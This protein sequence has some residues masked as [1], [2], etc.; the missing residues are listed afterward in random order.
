[1]TRLGD[2]RSAL[3]AAYPDLSDAELVQA[4]EAGGPHFAS[5]IVDHGL[6]PLW[7]ERTERDEFRESRLLAEALYAAQEHALGEID[8]VLNDA[9]VKYAVIKGAASRLLL[10]ENPAIRA[11]HDIDLLVRPEDRVKATSALV[12]A[13]FVATLNPLSISHEL[14][15]S[16]HPIEIDLHWGLLR[17]GRLRPDCAVGMIERRRRSNGLWMLD[18]EDAFFVLVVHP[19]FAKHLAGWEMGLHRVADIAAWLPRQS[20]DWQTVL[21]RLDENGVRTAAWA[22]LRWVELLT[23]PNTP[24]GLNKML[25]ELCPGKLRR[26]WLEFW[27]RQ[28][29]TE[30]VSDSAHWVRLLGFSLFLH[31]KPGD[32]VRAL[33]GRCRAHRRSG[34]DLTAFADLSS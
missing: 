2:Y 27:L 10:H 21:A 26:S 31:D 4:L 18:A 7:H 5:F 14:T 13:G 20:S 9:G 19:A 15:L 23:S 25:S 8:V 24:V 11:C 16:R 32:V 33:A 6:G 30:R 34:A 3:L 22:T 29:L 12:R 17:D 28:N 1:M